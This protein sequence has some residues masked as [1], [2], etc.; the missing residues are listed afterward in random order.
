MTYIDQ[1]NTR[2]RFDPCLEEGR[3]DRWNPMDAIRC[4]PNARVVDVER[5]AEILYPRCNDDSGSWNDLARDLFMGF[6]LYLLETPEPPCTLGEILGQI[7]GD[8][9][10][11]KEHVQ[12]IL[13]HRSCGEFA[14]SVPCY[15]AFIRFCSAQEGLLSSIVTVATAPLLIFQPIGFGE[16]GT[17][18][19]RSRGVRCDVQ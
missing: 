19:N 8:G 10:L 5:L 17:D 12:H 9:H 2:W 18:R 1:G 3:T 15:Q 6:A 7:R 13:A 16:T 4:D 11:V 14:L